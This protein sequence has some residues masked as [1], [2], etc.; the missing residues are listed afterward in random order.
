MN[1]PPRCKGLDIRIPII[2]P[3]K[4]RRFINQRSTLAFLDGLDIG[5]IR[6]KPACCDCRIRGSK[7]GIKLGGLEDPCPKP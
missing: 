6:S 1:T 4:G 3:M 5:A 2:I 7:G